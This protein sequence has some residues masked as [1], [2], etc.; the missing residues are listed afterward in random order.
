MGLL[1]GNFAVPG[2]A[3]QEDTKETALPR[4][5]QGARLGM[6]LSEFVSLVP[7]AKR[8]SLNRGDRVQRTIVIPSKEHPIRHVE[9]RFYNDHLR[10][11]AIHYT[12]NEVPGGF[13]VLRQ[14]LQETYGE[15]TVA[16]QTEYD[17]GP[18]IASVKKTVWK[19]DATM[20]V[21]AQFLK[22]SQGQERYDLVLTI[23]DRDLQQMFEKDQE[24]RRREET[25]RI[26]IPLP[27]SRIQN[28]QTAMSRV[29]G[30]PM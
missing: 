26:P 23:T 29:E 20:S 30:T 25:L 12:Y 15:P 8:V 10:E 3:A 1:L 6:T 19:D 21:L 2:M 14:R 7:D 24:Q 11:L 22:L 16:E 27:G 17:T 18:N 13:T 9:Y 4:S 28:K 5:F